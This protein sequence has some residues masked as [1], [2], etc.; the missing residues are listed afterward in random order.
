MGNFVESEEIC[1][2]NSS[3]TAASAMVAWLHGTNPT[4]PIYGS[5]TYAKMAQ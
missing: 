1:Y 4:H 2:V 3:K 5:W